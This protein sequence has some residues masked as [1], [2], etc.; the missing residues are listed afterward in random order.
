MSYIYAVLG[1][2]RQ[3][4]AAAYDMARFGDASKVLIDD[5]NL[6]AATRAAERVNKLVGQEIVEA[7]Q[8]DVTHREN[9]FNF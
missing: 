8:L 2:G 3:G 5:M 6:E 1:G 4:T 9:L 7:H